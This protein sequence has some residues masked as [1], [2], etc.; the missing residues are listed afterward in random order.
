MKKTV[1]IAL[2]LALFGI[3]FSFNAFAEEISVRD[4][5]ERI[6]ILEEQAKDK[7][8]STGW[9]NRITF[10]GVIE[11]EAAYE[12]F[13][14]EGP[15]VKDED[16]SD[17]SL[18]KAELGVDVAIASHVDGHVLLL[19]EDDEDVTVDEAFILL[20]GKDDFPLYLKA[21]KLYVPFGRYESNMISDPLTLEL[22]ETRETAVEVGFH[23][24]GVY[25]S[26]FVFNGEMD[27]DE[28]DDRINNYGA[29]IGYAMERDNFSFDIGAGWINNIYDSNGLTDSL[30]ES[31]A[32]AESFGFSASLAE[33]V[34]GLAAYAVVTV[35]PVTVIGE[36]VAMLEDTKANLADIT[37]GTLAAFG[38]GDT[39]KADAFEAWNLEVGYKF[40]VVGKPMLVGVGYQGVTNGEEG[41]PESRYLGVVSVEIMDSTTVSLEYRHDEYETNDEGNAVTAML[42]IEF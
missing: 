7:A 13:D 29:N 27:I 19:Y 24:Y 31:Y 34:P 11:F 28:D 36:Y 2:C 15:A 6:G 42:A 23:H 17:F 10:S 40:E 33:E 35:G 38:Y 1:P 4:L 5:A 26:V 18:S 14:Y 12:E 3:I 16:T 41:Y 22:G 20:D 9:A 32:E 39:A 8:S 37:P 21:G 30:D 25:G